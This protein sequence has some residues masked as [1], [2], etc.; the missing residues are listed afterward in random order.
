MIFVDI[1]IHYCQSLLF[2]IGIVIPI[3]IFLKIPQNWNFRRGFDV[4]P[5]ACPEKEM[6]QQGAGPHARARVEV[7][8][9]ENQFSCSE[10]AS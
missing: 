7:S 1:I 5:S 9:M 2:I 10:L 4:R 3:N 6:Y 8:K